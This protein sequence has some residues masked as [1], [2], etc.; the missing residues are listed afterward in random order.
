MR[1][2]IGLGWEA[3]DVQPSLC[4]SLLFYLLYLRVTVDS[5]Q[6][7]DNN[8]YSHFCQQ[9]FYE[10]YPAISLCKSYVGFHISI[11]V[12]ID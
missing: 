6:R 1:N 12:V 7:I 8:L 10:T 3:E 5:N 9:H 4:H 2:V 11:M